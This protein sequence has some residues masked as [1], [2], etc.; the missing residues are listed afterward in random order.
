MPK[1]DPA[2]LFYSK[3]WLEGTAEMT[4]EEKGIYIDLLAH[5]HQKG[6]LP[7]ETKR[8]AKLVGLGE[9]EFTKIWPDVSKKF[10]VNSDNRLV[11]LKLTE[12]TTER[13]ERGHKNKII[14]AL[15]VAVRQ[16]KLA[17]EIKYEAKKGFDVNEFITLQEPF[18][19]EKVTE[20]FNQRL[21]S[22][23]NANGNANEDANANIINNNTEIAP[24]MFKIFK[25]QNPKYPHDK[26]KDFTSC[27]SMAYKIAESKG[28]KQS[29][30]LTLKKAEVLKSWEKIVLFCTTDKWFSTRALY[31]LNNEWQR[32]I[33]SMNGKFSGEHPV[34]EVFSPIKKESQV[35]FEKYKKNLNGV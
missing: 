21:K 18:I 17:Y 25:N 12:I 27:L 3:D 28:W 26:Q 8:L 30:V 35:N 14:S 31:D 23:A 32:L 24:E 5:Q 29:D 33:Q 7:A 2:F 19:T 16:S 4:S 20:W 15:A 1:K 13:L 22:I 6:T 34:K 10:T 11:N 9:G